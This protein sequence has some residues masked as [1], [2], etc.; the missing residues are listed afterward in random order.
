[1]SKTEQ[2]AETRARIIAAALALFATQGYDA[3]P[4]SEIASQSGVSDRTFFLHFPTKADVIIDLTSDRLDIFTRIVLDC[5]AADPDFKVLEDSL[6]A[7]HNLA[8]DRRTVHGRTQLL[9]RAAALSPTVR[10]KE[11][12][13]NEAI[14]EAASLAIARRRQLKEPT[15]EIKIGTAVALRVFHGIV[16]EWAV[17]RKANEFETV[18]RDHFRAFRRAVSADRRRA[19][20]PT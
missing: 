17:R 12:D 3:T 6:I 10:G 1:V 4:V 8:G 20:T 19:N 16:T 18:A 9:M 5:K 11:F 14:A 13:A 7:W 2:K 15:L